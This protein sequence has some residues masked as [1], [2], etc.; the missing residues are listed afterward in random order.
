MNKTHWM[1]TIFPAVLFFAGLGFTATAGNLE[2]D[3]NHPPPSAQPRVWWH[4]MGG[5]V[6]KEGITKDLEAM[7]AFGISG[8]TIFHLTSSGHGKRWVKPISNSLCPENTYRSQIWWRFMKHAADEADRCGLELGM[9][10]CPGWPTTSPSS[11]DPTKHWLEAI[12]AKSL[13]PANLYEA[14]LSRRLKH[15]SRPK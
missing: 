15:L 11:L 2:Q 7:K 8:A 6:S 4:W 5:N 14:Q 9:H 10:N 1:L 12:P 13:T 3:F